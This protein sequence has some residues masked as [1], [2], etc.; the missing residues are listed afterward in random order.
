MPLATTSVQKGFAS[1]AEL[2]GRPRS[3]GRP[4]RRLRGTPLPHAPSPPPR[5][6]RRL[7]R[8]RPRPPR[9]ARRSPSP[10]APTGPDHRNP[11]RAA[12]EARE[13]APR[14][15]PLLRRRGPCSRLA[16]APFICLHQLQRP[17]LVQRLVEVAALRALHAGGAAVGAGALADQPLGVADQALEL[18]VAAAGDPDAARV[19]VVDEDRRRPV[20]W[21]TLVERPPMSQRSHIA[22]S[23]STAICPCSVACR[24]PSRTSG[25]IWPAIRCGST[26]QSAWVRKFCSG[27]SS[28]TMSIGSWSEIETSLVGDHLLGHRDLA[29]VELDPGDLRAARGSARCRSRSPSSAACTSRRRRASTTA[30]RPLD[31]ELARP[32]RS[33]RGAGRPRPGG[34]W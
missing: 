16:R 17:R 3:R 4:P 29:E 20:W 15:P 13:G 7:L 18:L 19:A 24:A 12:L 33:A 2:P 5:P 6:V 26:Y 14:S 27:S 30:R 23:G 11:T 1:A 8:R 28:E 10:G 34:P 22:I 21:W 25:G 9:R 31:V 32:R